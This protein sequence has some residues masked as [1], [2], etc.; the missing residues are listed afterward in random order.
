MPPHATAT[1][2]CVSHSPLL[3]PLPLFI[4]STS[5]R[6]VIAS[7][8]F[9][10]PF[11]FASNPRC[12]CLVDCPILALCC[13]DPQR[14]RHLA[15]RASL[16]TSHTWTCCHLDLGSAFPA[17]YVFV[18]LLVCYSRVPSL[19]FYF[20]LSQPVLFNTAIASSSRPSLCLGYKIHFHFHFDIQHSL[21]CGSVPGESNF[22]FICYF[23]FLLTRFVGYLFSRIGLCVI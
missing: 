20:L 22:T 2:S 11:G 12:Q 15:S 10:F 7:F 13:Q 4:V 3:P 17:S 16:R 14:T 18:I 9:I 23:P 5:L 21:P 1:K 8:I 19:D 6:S